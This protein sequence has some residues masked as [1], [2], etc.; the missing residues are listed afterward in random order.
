MNF[1]YVRRHKALTVTIG[2]AVLVTAIGGLSV[3]QAV[4][5]PTS[6]GK[7]VSTSPATLDS[8]TKVTATSTNATTGCPDGTLPH[9]DIARFPD[10]SEA[11]A[12]TVLSA[13]QELDPSIKGDDVTTTPFGPQEDAPVWADASGTTYLVS[14]LAKGGWFASPS[15]LS[16]C[17]SLDSSMSV[18]R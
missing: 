7:S 17:D 18:A 14:A 3:A 11:G 4:D 8:T 2:S 6:A 13:L 5:S 12:D 1:H 16:G 15:T 10:D 9:L